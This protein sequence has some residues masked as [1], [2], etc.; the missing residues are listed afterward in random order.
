MKISN[1]DKWF[2][3]FIRLK[4]AN[5]SNGV[6]FVKCCTCGAIRQAKHVDCGHYVK[7]QHKATRWSEL[8]CLPQCKPC[9]GYEQGSPEK[10]AKEIDRL[11]GEGTA[12]RLK[13]LEKTVSKSNEDLIAL[14]YKTAV[15]ELLKS[16]NWE[17]LKWW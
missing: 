6:L 1:A 8:N 3:Y 2:S 5:E 15:N 17:N 10:M 16:K 4:Y 11:H 13:L 9:N 14:Y 7:R 12:E